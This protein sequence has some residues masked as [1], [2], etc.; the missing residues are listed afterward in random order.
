MVAAPVVV[1]AIP[2]GG[3]VVAEPIAERLGA[4]LTVV[5]AR[6]LTAPVAPE[7]AFGSLDEDGQV[8]LDRDIVAMVGLA[9]TDIERARVRVAAEIK[10]RMGLYGTPPI[11]RYL[12]G[13]GVVLVDDGLATGLTMRAAVAYAR[14]HG[15][16]DI[17]VAVP[18]SSVQAAERFRREAD[19]FV[20]PVVDPDFA[21][22]GAY[23]VDFSAVSDVE[24]TEILKR[25]RQ[26]VPAPDPPSALL[27]SFKSSRGL[28]L[29]GELLLPASS[30]PHPV[31]VFAHDR[32]EGKESPPDRAMAGGLRAE[33]I[34]A[35]LFDFTGHGASEGAPEERTPAQ[36]VDDLRAA[37]DVLETL[38]EIDTSRLGLIGVGSGAAA[39]L[40]AAG[41]RPAVRAVVLRSPEPGE[42]EAAAARVTAPTL[43]LAGERDEQSR[44][45]GEALLH[46]LGG[47][48]RLEVVPGGDH[49]FEDPAA[50]RQAVG[51]AT[52]WLRERLA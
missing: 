32:G 47:P 12:P 28:G 17:T 7:L 41:E 36:E 21:A 29:A 14:R 30:G 45:A 22:V 11:G 40:S 39:A 34:A 25:A 43:L 9:P 42:S 48:R 8:I 51:L 23:Y 6:K 3:V 16:R 2:R 24:V 5:Y 18:C 49:R 46:G 27:L 35:F 26:R 50:L 19:H 13:S 1:A 52:A 20:S 37:L 38:D 15:A 44:A 10:R 31:V 33:G 4:P